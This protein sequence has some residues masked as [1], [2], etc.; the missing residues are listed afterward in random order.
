MTF[1]AAVDAV[2][3][4]AEASPAQRVCLV[5][6]VVC[7]ERSLEALAQISWHSGMLETVGLQN[8][9]GVGYAE[10]RELVGPVHCA[11]DWP[12]RRVRLDESAAVDEARRV[13]PT[14]AEEDRHQYNNE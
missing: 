2:R 7:G 10:E 13:D 14:G 8:G 12:A 4:F 9:H 11:P 6:F 3:H 5:V 1:L